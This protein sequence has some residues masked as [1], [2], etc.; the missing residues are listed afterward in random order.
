MSV[1]A[2]EGHIGTFAE[3]YVAESGMAVIAGTGQH[4]EVSVDFTRKKD[5]VAV[6]WQER[7]FES[8]KGREVLGFGDTDRSAVEVLTPDDIVG[9]IDLNEPRIIGIK[10]H[11]RLTVLIYERYLIG[12]EIPMQAVTASAEVDM[13]DTIALFA[14]ENADK[15]VI[16]WHDSAVED[17]CDLRQRI[18]VYDRVI[19]MSPHRSRTAGRHILPWHIRK[20][21]TDEFDP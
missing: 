16:I 2:P 19:T 14:A 1:S 13:R 15:S 6:I 17:P 9:I 18:S 8:C 7:V 5:S 3:E 10:R 12:V 4:D 21:R 20:N 11:K